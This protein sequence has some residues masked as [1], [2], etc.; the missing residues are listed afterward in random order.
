[1]HIHLHPW[2]TWTTCLIATPNSQQKFPC[3]SAANRLFRDNREVR[4][5][6]KVMRVLTYL[7]EHRGEVVSRL[8]DGDRVVDLAFEGSGCAISTASSPSFAKIA[9]IP[10]RCRLNATRSRTSPSSSTTSILFIGSN[11]VRQLLT[12]QERSLPDARLNKG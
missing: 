9:S 11:G 12:V 7:V 3:C 4:L 2:P 10:L 1:M 5:E 8:V 6:P